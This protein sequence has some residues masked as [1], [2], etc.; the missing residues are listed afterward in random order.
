MRLIDDAMRDLHRSAAAKLLYALLLAG[1]AVAAL[2]G[3]EAAAA[4]Y[5]RRR[6]SGRAIGTGASFVRWRSPT[7]SSASPHAFPAR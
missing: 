7:S 3:P 5:A 2:R 6:S 4:R 1:C